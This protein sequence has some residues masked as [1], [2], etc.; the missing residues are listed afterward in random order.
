MRIAVAAASAFCDDEALIG[1]REVVDNLAGVVIR[2]NR[3]EGN[4]DFEILSVPATPI[5]AFA[6]SPTFCAK[7]VIVSKL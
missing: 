7:R 4:L 1:L 5:A 2:D 6:V 3:A